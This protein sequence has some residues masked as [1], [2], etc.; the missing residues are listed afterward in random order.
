M[1]GKKFKYYLKNKAGLYYYIDN[2]NSVQLTPV[3]IELQNSPEKWQDIACSLIHKEKYKSNHASISTPF[4]FNLSSKKILDWVA[5][6]E[7]Q[8]GYLEIVIEQQVPDNFSYAFL[9]SGK[10]DFKTYSYG[11]HESVCTINQN[12][13]LEILS[14]KEDVVLEFPLTPSNSVDV[15]MDGINLHYKTD[16]LV[17]DGD[18][19]LFGSHIVELIDVSNENQYA[20]GTKR[21]KFNLPT[22]PNLGN[23]GQH[24][25]AAGINGNVNI[26]FDFTARIYWGNVGISIPPAISI[27]Y[28]I[29]KRQTDGNFVFVTSLYSQSGITNVF[30]VNSKVH[31]IQ[32]NVNI[33]VVAGE[34][35]YFWFLPNGMNGAFDFC[36]VDY[37]GTT[38]EFRLDTVQRSPQTI[39]KGMRPHI[40]WQEIVTKAT[41]NEYSGV[42]PFLQQSSIILIPGTSLRKDN[43]ITLQTTIKD[44]L[45]Y[46]YVNELAV[47]TNTT[48]NTGT[49]DNFLT[50]FQN[51]ASMSLGLVR[52]MEWK[53]SPR[54]TISSVKVGYN[55]IDFG[56]DGQINGKSCVR[57]CKPLYF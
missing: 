24:F 3:K 23:T 13:L 20:V 31:T 51:Q 9:Y 1:Q 26:A 35:L 12:D 21:T 27:N 6:Y 28:L 7:G 30:G 8:Q 16:Y 57:Y 34:L 18:N 49:I 5:I 2:I 40:L 42:S 25:Y 47:I 54:H 43:V 48:N 33:N 53:F 37:S 29:W 11:E 4:A 10:L 52:D 32:G 46:C 15:L 41:N 50:T 14:A 17:S 44:F 38:M 45:Q 39:H 56:V 19:P 55:N 22:I 36:G